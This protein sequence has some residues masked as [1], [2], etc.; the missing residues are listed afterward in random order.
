M[1]YE[2]RQEIAALEWT[3]EE[4]RFQQMLE[5]FLEYYPVNV[6]L[7]FM[8][9]TDLRITVEDPDGPPYTT[10]EAEVGQMIGVGIGTS[11]IFV[12][13]K[14]AFFADFSAVDNGYNPWPE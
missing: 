9:S 6:H 11:D 4:F 1:R 12:R 5:M 7:M 13:T 3:G 2:R 10:L 14:Q 8:E